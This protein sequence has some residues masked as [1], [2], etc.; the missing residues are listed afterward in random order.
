MN[1]T[2]EKVMQEV[3]IIKVGNYAGLAREVDLPE[4]HKLIGRNVTGRGVFIESVNICSFDGY[5]LVD[6]RTSE[7][8]PDIK[9]I[10]STVGYTYKIYPEVTEDE[11]AKFLSTALWVKVD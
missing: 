6:M 4:V 7:P 3:K 1:P 8:P 5:F 2:K 9:G 11:F 10:K